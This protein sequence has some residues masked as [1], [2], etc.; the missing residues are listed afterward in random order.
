MD[1]APS[2]IP[3]RRPSKERRTASNSA[4]RIERKHKTEG[5]MAEKH[6]LRVLTDTETDE[7][8]GGKITLV[9]TTTTTNPAGNPSPGQGNITETT[10]TTATNPAGNTAVGQEEETVANPAPPPA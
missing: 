1:P 4:G 8:S 10:T 6:I 7:V 9:T 3:N 2:K 5:K